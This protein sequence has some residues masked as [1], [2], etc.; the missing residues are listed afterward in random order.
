[1]ARATSKEATRL[2]FEYLKRAY[3]NPKIDVDSNFYSAW[4]DVGNTKFD[5]WWKEHQA[6]LLGRMTQAWS[7]T[8]PHSRHSQK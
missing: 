2:W 6:E 3:Q 8:A 4:G 5:T 1:M 7:H